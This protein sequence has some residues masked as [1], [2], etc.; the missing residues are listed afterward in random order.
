MCII[1][2]LFIGKCI[3]RLDL[4]LNAVETEDDLLGVEVD[5]TSTNTARMPFW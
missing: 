2:L 3:V 4:P 1:F 5:E